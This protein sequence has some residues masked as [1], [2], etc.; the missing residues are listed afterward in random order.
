MCRAAP[1]LRSWVHLVKYEDLWNDLEDRLH[2][3]ADKL[4]A[5]S[6]SSSVTS[7]A[8]SEFERQG[9]ELTRTKWRLAFASNRRAEFN[10]SGELRVSDASVGGVQVVLRNMRR[11]APGQWSAVFTRLHFQL[12]NA[13]GLGEL[14]QELD[15]RQ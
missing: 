12:F 6:G 14:M 7:E 2:T 3:V 4:F 13:T 1:E 10:E 9:V 8:K 5:W 11:G 15:Y